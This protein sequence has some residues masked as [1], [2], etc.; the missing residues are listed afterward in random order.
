VL[1]LK[2]DKVLCFDTLSKVFILKVLRVHENRGKST[3]ILKGFAAQ[4]VERL[5]GLQVERLGRTEERTKPEKEA[6][7]RSRGVA[8]REGTGI[9]DKGRRS[10]LRQ[11]QRQSHYNT[12]STG[13]QG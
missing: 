6:S 2:V 12:N 13:S 10:F 7:G 1:I 3:L 4:I 11:G 8:D 5:E 9:A